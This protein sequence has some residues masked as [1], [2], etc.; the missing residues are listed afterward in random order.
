ML[1]FVDQDMPLAN[2]PEF[3][4]WAIAFRFGMIPVLTNCHYR[5]ES[6]LLDLVLDRGSWN[7]EQCDRVEKS[8]GDDGGAQVGSEDSRPNPKILGP[9]WEKH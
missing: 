8:G 2:G 4:S 6:S 7:V 3:L 5:G 1:G 9:K